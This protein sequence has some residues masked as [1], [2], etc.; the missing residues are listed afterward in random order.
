MDWNKYSL[1]AEA[2]ADGG[3]SGSSK[4]E[5]E[6]DWAALS[7]DDSFVDSVPEP[8]EPVPAPAPVVKPEP[9]PVPAPAQPTPP[10][11]SPPPAP[12]QQQPQPP[13]VPA[14]APTP[15]P[16]QPSLE[17]LRAA[18]LTRLADYY[19]LSQDETSR[20]AVEPEKVLPSLAARLHTSI[21]EAVFHGL[22]QALPRIIHEQI[23]ARESRMQ[24]ETKFYGMFP[25]L[26][27]DE[28]QTQVHGALLFARQLNPHGTPEQI[29][30]AAG[31]QMSIQLGLPLPTELGGAPPPPPQPAP[32]TPAG[33]GAPRGSAPSSSPN[34]NPFAVL[35][36]EMLTEER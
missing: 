21:A 17:E 9:A 8:A 26:K 19:Q 29:M 28:Y 30:R 35:A 1:F 20:F 36:N 22:G 11:V 23:A 14:P 4:P 15:A 34:D 32:F 6:V 33:A 5:G 13:V 24:A 16:P 27:K 31:V 12:T 7:G 18:E 25:G 2:P 10:V 3:A